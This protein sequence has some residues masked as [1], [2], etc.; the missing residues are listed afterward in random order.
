[1]ETIIVGRH[2]AYLADAAKA[3]AAARKVAALTGAGISVGSGV[4]D[5]RSPGGIWTLYAPEEYATIH[6]FLQN[7][8]KAWKLFRALGKGLLGKKPNPAHLTLAELERHG[9]LHGI[10]TQ[11]IDNLHQRAGNTTVFEIHGNHLH[12]QC[13][14][15]GYLEPVRESHYTSSEVPACADCNS[16]LKPNIVL[17]GEAVRG[18]DAIRAFIADCDLLLVIGTSAQVYPAAGIPVVVRQNGG[19]IFEFNMEPT[20]SPGLTSYFFAGDAGISLPTFARAVLGEP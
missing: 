16:P 1:M 12:L 7:P 18:L 2:E 3:F 17:F 6:T 15:C 10:V 13:V 14:R 11:N 8:A 9:L 4:S 19:M 20:L 5:F